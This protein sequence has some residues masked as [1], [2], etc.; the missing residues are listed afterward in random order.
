M[1]ADTGRRCGF[2]G[3]ALAFAALIMAAPVFAQTSNP[4]PDVEVTPPAVSVL[5]EAAAE[6]AKALGAYSEALAVAAASWGSPLVT[7]IACA[8]MMRLDRIRRPP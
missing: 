4:D 6:R 3:G 7:I 1:A 8:T 2:F 5:S